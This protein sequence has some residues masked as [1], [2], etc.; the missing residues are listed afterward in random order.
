MAKIQLSG[1]LERGPRTVLFKNGLD[2]EA[3][4]VLFAKVARAHH[5]VPF[6]HDPSHSDVI[7]DRIYR[8]IR[9]R[10]ELPFE[11]SPAVEGQTFYL[12]SGSNQ[13]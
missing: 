5:L 8:D 13:N 9:K 7:L 1:P 12:G 2:I 6:H 3:A 10:H 4:V 11:L